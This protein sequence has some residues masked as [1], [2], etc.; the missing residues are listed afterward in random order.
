MGPP[1]HPTRAQNLI[2]SDEGNL[3]VAELALTT[4]DGVA[5][6]I[7]ND[8]TRNNAD[9]EEQQQIASRTSVSDDFEQLRPQDLLRGLENTLVV[10]EAVDDTKNPP[11]SENNA[12]GIGRFWK[13]AIVFFS[14]CHIHRYRCTNCCC[15]VRFTV[16][17]A[18]ETA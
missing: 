4:L 7:M 15:C 9:V 17:A 13:P 12:R 18:K 16:T 2:S 5:A 8:E 6:P 11:T 10:A 1:S 3:V 14:C